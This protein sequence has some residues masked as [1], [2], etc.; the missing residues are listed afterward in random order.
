MRPQKE[1]VKAWT[2]VTIRSVSARGRPG[3]GALTRSVQSAHCLLSASLILSRTA[4]RFL[5]SFFGGIV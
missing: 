4:L 5:A 3:E 2:Q 1:V